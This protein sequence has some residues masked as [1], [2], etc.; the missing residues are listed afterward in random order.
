[1]EQVN[2]MFSDANREGV[3]LEIFKDY[4]S[5]DDQ[6]TLKDSPNLDT[7][8]KYAMYSDEG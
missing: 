2:L 1:M 3:K 8:V 6:K 7:K 4:I 5:Y